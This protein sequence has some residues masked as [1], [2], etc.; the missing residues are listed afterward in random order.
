MWL[1]VHYSYV[2]ACAR[3]SCECVGESV[4]GGA[5]FGEPRLAHHC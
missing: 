5:G 2:C 4:S 3:V 1:S